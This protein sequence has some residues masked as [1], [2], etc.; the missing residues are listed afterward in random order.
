M[1][2][3]T[4]RPMNIN[5]YN[6]SNGKLSASIHWLITKIYEAND[7][8][9]NLRDVFCED[10]EGN[11]ELLPTI[12]KCLTSG[13]FYAQAASKVLKNNALVAQH[14][15]AVLGALSSAGIDVREADG[16]LVS[17]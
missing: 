3:E 4:S 17:L 8:P 16:S 10:D 15:G 12:I 7:I 5:N 11:L 1:E 6:P 2:S 14:I 13:S 9:D